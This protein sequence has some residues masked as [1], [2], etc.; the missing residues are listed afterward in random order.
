[1]ISKEDYA[2]IKALRK[3]GVYVKDIAA[4]LGVHPKTV[5]R[6]LAREGAPERKR[7][8][9][10][11]K[12]DPYKAQIDQLL[13]EGVWN[14]VVIY[15]EIQAAGYEGKTTI[16]RD[17]IAPKRALRAGR[18]TVRFETKPGQQLQSDW[19][20][21]ETVIGG[22]SQKVYFE[23]NQLGYSRRFHF[24]GTDRM[25]AEH[26]YEGLVRSF[27]YF[28]GVPQEVL[29][30]NQKVAVVSNNGRGQVRFNERFLDLAGHYGFEPKAC[31]PYRART[32]GK[33]ERMVGYIKHHF[34]VRYRAFESWVH[35]NQVAEQ[36]LREEADQRRHGTVHEVVAER[37]EREAPTLVPLPTRRYDTSYRETRQVSW[38]SYIEVRGNRYSVP[39][40]L[41]GQTVGVRIGLD[42]QLWVY[43]GE[44]LVA[45]HRL[46]PAEQGWVTVPEHHTSLWQEAL[47]VEQRPLNVYQ[48]AAQWS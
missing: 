47:Q 14:G 10:S 13:Q 25:D 41:S 48:E 24:W 6:A 22:E 43:E 46:Q 45:Q 23:V 2:V 7:K 36:W 28:G 1:M 31:R 15:R 16:L 5:S 18:A 17:Y 42:D 20:E 11:S 38:D 33:D 3:H 40:K 30:D 4:E 19:G 39:A 44:S 32:K 9:G 8:R 12:L 26:T 21:I 34:F 35:L 29:V 27:E 37:F